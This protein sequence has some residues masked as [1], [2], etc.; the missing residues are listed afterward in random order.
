MSTARMAVA[1]GPVAHKTWVLRYVGNPD[2]YEEFLGNNVPSCRREFT[3]S[4]N[5]IYL[6]YDLGVLLFASF[7]DMSKLKFL[8]Q[9]DGG[10]AVIR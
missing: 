4:D 2:G 7:H 3:N 10:E 9:I 1:F 8:F 6:E 5:F